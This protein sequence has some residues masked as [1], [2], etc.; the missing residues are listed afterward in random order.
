MTPTEIFKLFLR[1]G[2]DP[3]ERLALTREIRTKIHCND[4]VL[5]ARH[6]YNEQIME[7]YDLENVFADRLIITT[8]LFSNT[9]GPYGSW[10]SCYNLSSFMKYL[11]YYVPS[12]IGDARHKNKYLERAN[13]EIPKNKGYKKYWQ[14]RLI[15]K[16]HEFLTKYVKNYDRYIYSY[17]TMKYY[18]LK[19]DIRL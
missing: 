16:W 4:T 6:W 15:K 14:L 3:C 13:V 5:C 12:I 8:R 7:W 2:V 1:H 17:D 10:T 11:L 19:D 9:L 18:K